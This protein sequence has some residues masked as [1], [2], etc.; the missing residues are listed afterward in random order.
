MITQALLRIIRSYR[1]Y[2]DIM[3][4]QAANNACSKKLDSIQYN[5]VLAVTR[6]IKGTACQKLFN[7][8]GMILKL[9]H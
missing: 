6:A 9:H 5:A 4:E 1:D 2:T 3:S 8:F 7:Y